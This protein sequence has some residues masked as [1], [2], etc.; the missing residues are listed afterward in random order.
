[1]LKV[2]QTLVAALKQTNGLAADG[3]H[4]LPGR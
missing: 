2:M 1:M 4:E 3:N